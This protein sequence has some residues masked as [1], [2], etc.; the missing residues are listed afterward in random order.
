MEGYGHR[1]SLVTGDDPEAVHQNSPPRSTTRS[2]TSPDPAGGARGPGD[3]TP[4]LPMIAAHAEGLD[5]PEGGRRQA[6]RG[7]VAL[8]P[9]ADVDVRGNKAH[10]QLLEEWMHLSAGGAFDERGVLV[11]ELAALGRPASC[12]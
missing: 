8:A 1:P 9:G 2:T 12:A 10:V 5:R 7:N 6:G 3:R 4:A 11:E